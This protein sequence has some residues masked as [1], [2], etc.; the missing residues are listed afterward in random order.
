MVTDNKKTKRW[1]HNL[2]R[3]K[4][5][6]VKHKGDKVVRFLKKGKEFEFKDEKTN[7]KIVKAQ[8]LKELRKAEKAEERERRRATKEAIDK[9]KKEKEEHRRSKQKKGTWILPHSCFARM[10]L[11]GKLEYRERKLAKTGQ[12][13]WHWLRKLPSEPEPKSLRLD[14]WPP[15]GIQEMLCYLGT[16]DPRQLAE[17]INSRLARLKARFVA[18]EVRPL[19]D[20]DENTSVT[21][22]FCIQSSTEL[23]ESRVLHVQW[24]SWW[25]LLSRH[26]AFC[27]L[28][29]VLDGLAY[30]IGT[31]TTGPNQDIVVG[32]L[33]PSQV[34][35]LVGRAWAEDKSVRVYRRRPN[36]SFEVL[37]DSS[38]NHVPV[39][40]QEAD[41]WEEQQAW[42]KWEELKKDM[43]TWTRAIE[44]DTADPWE[45]EE[46]GYYSKRQK[47]YCDEDGNGDNEDGAE[48]DSSSFFE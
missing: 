8:A 44:Q 24:A 10:R 14:A 47:L 32:E 9:I 28:P 33:S 1:Q 11:T 13:S 22:I 41:E 20:K 17:R 23:P 48:S 42:P 29:R 38:Q 19:V 4:K 30:S 34:V 46:D 45:T 36:G 35:L 2:N 39:I 25:A 26:V 6:V 7:E 5:L 16:K 3:W 18:Q 40:A 15:T 31:S 43:G 21:D 27:P 12:L 37:W